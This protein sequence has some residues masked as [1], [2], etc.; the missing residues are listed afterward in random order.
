MLNTL[1]EL[2][3]FTDV[4]KSLQGK[5]LRKCR[6]RVESDELFDNVPGFV[7]KVQARSEKRCS[8]VRRIGD[9]FI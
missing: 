7:L 6:S 3:F 5:S 4:R 9:A 8:W 1:V 2:S